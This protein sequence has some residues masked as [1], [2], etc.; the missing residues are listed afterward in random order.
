[1][2]DFTIPFSKKQAERD[3]RMLK[4]NIQVPSEVRKALPTSAGLEV[5]SHMKKHDI[6]VLASPVRIFKLEPFIPTPSHKSH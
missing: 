1:M 3:I 4:L 6:P 5:L 2:N